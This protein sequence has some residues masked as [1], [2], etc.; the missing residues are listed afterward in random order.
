[1]ASGIDQ[2]VGGGGLQV[3]KCDT[4]WIGERC[5]TLDIRPGT[6]GIN[7][8]PLCAY[9]GDGPNSTSWGGSVI[10]APE[11]S[12]YYMWAASMV[13][14][15]TMGEWVTNSE[16]VLARSPTPYG[17][18]VDPFSPQFRSVCP[19]FCFWPARDSSLRSAVA[20]STR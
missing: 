18:Y 19:L 20:R 8:L 11:D 9:H 7:E 17:P 5:Q 15:C 1:M 12:Q 13:N 16:V 2:S 3:C 4:P 14:N 10:H 6:V